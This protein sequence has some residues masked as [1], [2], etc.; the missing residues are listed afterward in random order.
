MNVP[1]GY[2]STVETAEY[3][4]DTKIVIDITNTYTSQITE[5]HGSLYLGKFVKGLDNLPEDYTAVFEIRGPQYEEAKQIEITGNYIKEED[6]D[7][8]YSVEYLSDLK[9][10]E[11]T[12]T[13]IDVTKFDGYTCDT[14]YLSGSYK[15][16]VAN[17]L[18][19]QEAEP[20]PT[21]GKSVTVEVKEGYIAWADFF[22]TYTKTG[23]GYEPRLHTLTL[24]KQ[25]VGLDNVPEGYEVTVNITNKATGAVVKTVKLGANGTQT[26]FL[27]NGEYTLT[28]VSAAV[29]G[30]KQVGQT[31][32]A[33]DFKLNDSMSITV[34]NTYEKDAEEPIV[35][36]DPTEPATPVGP[37]KQDDED[38]AK[39]PKTGDNTPMSLAIYGILAAGALLGL[40]KTTKRETK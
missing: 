11:Y 38:Q 9:A 7:A 27:P 3:E 40:R 28:E 19:D 4:S 21:R 37:T 18:L 16:A 36:P 26:V 1:D 29:D 17:S 35:D 39:V 14:S 22:N 6:R 25:V 5:E 10:G 15:E 34:T 12:I 32:S 2:T 33:N 13:E 23:G 31:F 24:N 30:Y 20:S 8:Y